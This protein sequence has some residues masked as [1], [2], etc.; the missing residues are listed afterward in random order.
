MKNE[1]ILAYYGRAAWSRWRLLAC[2][3]LGATFIGW[4]V[5]TFILAH[6][7]TYDAEARLNVVPTGEELGYASRYARGQN[8]EGG[9]VMMQTY[10]EYLRSRELRGSVVDRWIASKAAQERVSPRQWIARQEAEGGGLSPGAIVSFLNYGKI[11][12]R[13]LRDELIEDLGKH[14][15]IDMIDG[16]FLMQIKVSWDDAEDA[17]W[18]ANAMSGAITS[19]VADLSE[20]SGETLTD[21]LRTELTKKQAELAQLRAS[22][23]R[24]KIGLGIVDI[25]RQKQALLDDQIAEQGRLTSDISQSRQAAAQVASLEAQVTGKLGQ[26]QTAIE[27]Q[28]ALA[29]PQA[30]AARQSIAARQARL[31]AIQGQLNRL[32]RA[33]LG[34]KTMDD[35]AAELESEVLALMERLRFSETE[36]LTNRAV[37]RLIDPAEVPLVRSSPKILLNTML[38]FVIGCALAGLLLLLLGPKAYKGAERRAAPATD[39][40][41]AHYDPVD[42]DHTE[43]NPHEPAFAM[44][45]GAEPA[46]AQQVRPAPSIA[47]TFAPAS[48]TASAAERDLVGLGPSTSMI[49]DLGYAGAADDTQTAT[50]IE[51]RQWRQEAPDPEPLDQP[52]PIEPP[53]PPPANPIIEDAQFAGGAVAANVLRSD[54]LLYVTNP[55]RGTYF[56]AEAVARLGPRVMRWLGDLPGAGNQVHV[57]TLTGD[58]VGARRLAKLVLDC[59]RAQGIDAKAIRGG[60]ARLATAGTGPFRIILHEQTDIDELYALGRSHS[61]ILLAMGADDEEHIPVVIDEFAALGSKDIRIAISDCP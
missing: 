47:S 28:L 20:N 46:F 12:K 11:V 21:V 56:D 27:Q 38:A 50:V 53:A 35:R 16:T 42:N 22:S 40:R 34:V 6:D 9:L 45:S 19:A 14:T 51:L 23:R 44:R 18:F 13:P 41:K 2:V 43:R 54:P 39:R 31:G 33:E 5:S 60:S 58:A 29:R 32:S 26:T 55:A 52:D 7:P 3:I 1:N 24:Q 49:G 59:C 17:A 36:N 8:A 48:A 57:G 15:Q 4:A 25:D 61:P 10:A 37:I 30:A